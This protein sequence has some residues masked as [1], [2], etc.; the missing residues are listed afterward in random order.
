MEFIVKEEKDKF[1][2]MKKLVEFQKTVKQP[3][4]DNFNPLSKSKYATL[5]SVQKSITE[6]MTPLGLSF[7]QDYVNDQDGKLISV[8]TIIVSEIGMIKFNPIVLPIEKVTAQGIGSAST[9]AR[10]Y[11]LTTNLSIVADEDDDGNQAS[12]VQ[13]N[14]NSNYKKQYTKRTQTAPKQQPAAKTTTKT[15]EKTTTQGLMKRYYNTAVE[16]L[17]K[18]NA[19]TAFNKAKQTMGADDPYTLNIDGMKNFINV[20]VQNVKEL[21]TMVGAE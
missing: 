11:A 7:F 6:A 18:S 20:F 3:E 4:K 10:R 9:Y 14:S 17:G 12:N 2:L 13:H 19:D 8:Q 15:D 21:K 16:Q 1:A 5:S